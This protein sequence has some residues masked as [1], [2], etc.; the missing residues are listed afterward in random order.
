MLRNKIEVVAAQGLT[1]LAYFYCCV[2]AALMV[3]ML[4]ILI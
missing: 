3:K 2:G 4:V 1:V